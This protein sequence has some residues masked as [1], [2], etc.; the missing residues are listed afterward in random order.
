VLPPL[1]AEFAK[2]LGVEDGDVEK[3]KAEVRTN[4]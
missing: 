4:L 3:L 2:A 1:N